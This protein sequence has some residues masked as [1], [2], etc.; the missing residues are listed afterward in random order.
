MY[1]KFIEKSITLRID[2]ILFFSVVAL[3]MLFLI[4]NPKFG[5][6]NAAGPAELILSQRCEE[7]LGK[8]LTE[9][10]IQEYKGILMITQPR[11][12]YSETSRVP[13]IRVANGKADLLFFDDGEFSDLVRDNALASLGPYIKTEN[14]SSDALAIPLVSHMDML[15]YNIDLLKAA[16][17][18][19][20]PKTR[21]EFLAW[22]KD[23][24]AAGEGIAGAALGLSPD[25]NKSL[26]R[27][28]Y[29]WIWAAGGGLWSENSQNQD[30]PV[31][32]T[33]V[34]AGVLSFLGELNREGIIT[35]QI[36]N[37]TGEDLLEE[38]AQGRIA[39]M[40]ATTRAISLLRE[41]M[42]DG[43][44]GVTAIPGVIDSRKSGVG[45]SYIYCGIS[46]DCAD[47]DRAWNFLG[48]LAGKNAV[49]SA[50]LEAVPGVVPG[51]PSGIPSVDY[52]TGDPFFSKAWDVFESSEIVHGFSG[53]PRAEEYDNAVREE[54]MNL[55]EQKSTAAEAAAA[56]Q[57][58][59]DSIFSRD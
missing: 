27:D 54:L 15:F 28:I 11:T 59:W 8:D 35:P 25:D 56:I 48:F 30:K 55:L 22:G 26:S 39:M 29:S 31:F 14:Y 36:F 53:V 45:L 32:N 41:K 6:S 49:I 57:N 19:R 16:G 38:F 44:F 13:Q 2:Y 51:L 5:S 20:P 47:P 23:I 17:F 7:L 10:L 37:K 33:P 4:I 3:V 9:K 52:I 34:A 12:I 18:V 46:S 42:G 21:A 50:G 43:A 40:I 58:R 1:R 24:G